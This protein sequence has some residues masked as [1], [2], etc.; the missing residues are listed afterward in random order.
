MT[1]DDLEITPEMHEEAKLNPNGW[2]Y[3][4]DWNFSKDQYV[5]PEAIIGA[6]K[7][8]E[9]GK[10]TGDLVENENYSAIIKASRKPREY[11]NTVIAP[12]MFDNWIV[13]IDPKFDDQFPNVPIEGQIGRWYL[14]RNGQYTGDFRPNREYKGNI[15]T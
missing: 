13:E 6:Y 7:V 9:N 1:I 14:D 12:H 5:P 3:K 15:E 2:V 8:D 10:I 4:I 11:M